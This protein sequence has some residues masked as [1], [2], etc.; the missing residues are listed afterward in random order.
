MGPYRTAA[1]LVLLALC[2]CTPVTDAPSARAE[3]QETIARVR[4]LA[5]D[6]AIERLEAVH[7]GGIDQWVSIRGA[8]RRNPILLVLHGGPGYVTMPSAWYFSRGLEDYFTIVHWDQ[9][10]AGR[11][12]AANDPVVMETLSYD[13]MLDDTEELIAWL[14]VEFGKE[15]IFVLGESWGSVLGVGI[16][17]R[18]PEWLHAYIGVG[19]AADLLES[20]RRGW[21]HA[22]ERARAE[23]NAEAIT[24]LEALAPYAEREPPATDDLLVQR[25]WLAH[26]GGVIYGRNGSSDFT[27][28]ARLSPDYD[29]RALEAVWDANEQS[30]QRLFPT[31]WARGDLRNV[32]SLNVPI[33]LF[34]G[35]HDYNVNSDVGAEWLARLRAP[36]KTLVWFERSGHEPPREEPGRFLVAL[37]THALPI[38]QRAGDIAP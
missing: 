2:A 8:D 29:A 1:A 16:A 4:S 10:G 17:Q 24:A 12:Y 38:A 23:D 7:V 33:L 32:T 21:R 37:V 19:Q 9:R 6:H 36:S 22:M 31:L 26:Y 35:R 20:E 28:A 18:R 5:G 13:R 14:R 34:S 25:R 27:A 15:R 11:T 3:V 30:V